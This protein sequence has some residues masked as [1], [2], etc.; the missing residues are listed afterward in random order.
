MGCT[1]LAAGRLDPRE[2]V[3][4]TPRGL[5]IRRMSAASADPASGT[6]CLQVSDA[7]RIESGRRTQPLRPFVIEVGMSD[8]LAGLDRIGLDLAFD[9]TVASCIKAGQPLAVSVGAPTIRL[10][11]NKV[12]P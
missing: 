2:I 4:D 3:A 10:P 7:D 8:L 12:S 9:T 6:A 5:F 1:F 11:V